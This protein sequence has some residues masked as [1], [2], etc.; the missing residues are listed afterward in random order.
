MTPGLDYTVTVS[1]YLHN[2]QGVLYYKSYLIDSGN[3]GEA[4]FDMPGEATCIYV[5][6]HGPGEEPSPDPNDPNKYLDLH[7]SGTQG[8]TVTLTPDGMPPM[9]SDPINPNGFEQRKPVAKDT[10]VDLAVSV[11]PGYTVSVSYYVHNGGVIT[12]TGTVDSTTGGTASFPMPEQSTCVYVTFK[13]QDNPD[14]NDPKKYLDLHVSGTN[15][16]TATLTAA[17]QTDPDRPE[18]SVQSTPEVPRGVSTI[19]PV[20]AGT[21]VTLDV[22]LTEG[23]AVTVT[24]YVHNGGV[25]TYTSYGIDSNTGGKATFNMPAQSTCIYVHFHKSDDPQPDPPD[26]PD[27]PEPKPELHIAYVTLK[28]TD[29]EPLNRAQDIVNTTTPGLGGGTLWAYGTAG[30]VML[31]TFTVAPGYTARVTAKRL[32][33]G[34]SVTVGQMGTTNSA[35][36]T[37]TMPAL[38]DAD[39]E[40]TITYS[41]DPVPD[42]QKHNL[43]LRLVGHGGEAGNYAILDGG[44]TRLE[45][46]GSQAPNG[47]NVTAST[48]AVFGAALDL[49]AYREN[50]YIF[51]RA[52]LEYTDS[53][54]TQVIDLTLSEYGNN[55]TNLLFMPDADAIV[56]VYYRLPYQATLFVVDDKGQ[57]YA[58]GA[59][60]DTTAGNAGAY[61]RVP[62]TQEILDLY[63]AVTR[64]QLRALA[65][66]LFR[67]EHAS[68]SAVGR[69][70]PAAHYAAW[71]GR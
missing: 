28:N 50:G 61:G 53:T 7:V 2:S 9:H 18:Q 66:E 44:D 60:G 57:D 26:P 42:T 70:G 5:A 71:L 34:A 56:T 52:T 64:E 14:P 30:D 39:M 21:P 35:T 54:G 12:V 20:K 33:T 45:L 1:Y 32:D 10:N 59:A 41:K 15:G 48:R 29:G 11:E 31:T 49:D 36:A 38:P 19:Q 6:F 4:T 63:D 40:V 55:G 25:F 43:T 51:A 3:G 46:H 8:G 65:G 27:P 37:A 13:R 62:E 47:A 22:T 17:A 23:Y 24:Y 69:V 68:L 16:G 58:G 67:T